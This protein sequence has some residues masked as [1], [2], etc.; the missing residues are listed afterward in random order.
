MVL[1]KEKAIFLVQKVLELKN[2]TLVQRAFRTKFKNSNVPRIKTIRGIYNR[3]LRSDFVPSSR[4]NRAKSNIRENAE[5]N[6]KKI[7]DKESRI[8]IRKAVSI[9]KCSYTTTR[10]ILKNNLKLKPYKLNVH[11][12]LYETDYVKRLE[13]ANRI[14]RLKHNPEFQMIACDEA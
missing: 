2:I 12:E 9:T 7:E 3:F 5:K 13:F 4:K 11:Q 1:E 10:D 6:Q 14:M 8:S